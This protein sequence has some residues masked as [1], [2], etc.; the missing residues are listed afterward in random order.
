MLWDPIYIDATVT[1]DDEFTKNNVE[2]FYYRDPI[3]L[4]SN[5]IESPANIQSQML[6]FTDF[7]GNDMFRI[8]R[9]ANPKCR[10]TYGNKVKYTEGKIIAYPFTGN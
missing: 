7:K 5:I 1:K 10:F 4:T 9:Y 8:V 2:V 3:L 6:I